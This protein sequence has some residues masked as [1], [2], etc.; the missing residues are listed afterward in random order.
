[1]VLCHTFAPGRSLPGA[2]ARALEIDCI[3][4][5]VREPQNLK[6]FQA[7]YDHKMQKN[8]WELPVPKETIR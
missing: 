4:P 7:L 8:E 5:V 2:N 3:D 6:L 1:M